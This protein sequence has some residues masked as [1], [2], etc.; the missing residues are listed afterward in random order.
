MSTALT[1]YPTPLS[2]WMLRLMLLQP[3][4][5]VAREEEP[6]ASNVSID[7]EVPSM[8]V[9]FHV[10]GCGFDGEGAFF[11]V[12]ASRP[13][14]ELDHQGLHGALRGREV[15]ALMIE[16]LGSKA[17]PTATERARYMGRRTPF[18]QRD[19]RA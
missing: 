12:R 13:R 19:G 14:L 11:A 17:L 2:L 10:C 3:S 4:S 9:A 18:G 6:A 7:L 15:L 8:A 5:Q 1:V 16:E